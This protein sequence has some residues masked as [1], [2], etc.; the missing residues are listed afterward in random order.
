M[1]NN[2]VLGKKGFIVLAIIAIVSLFIGIIA[3]NQTNTLDMKMQSLIK[4]NAENQ[5]AIKC[6]NNSLNAGAQLSP[7][8][9]RSVEEIQQKLYQINLCINQSEAAFQAPMRP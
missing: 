1:N 8:Y 9:K 7:T 5:A 2:W 4:D 3:W 6:V